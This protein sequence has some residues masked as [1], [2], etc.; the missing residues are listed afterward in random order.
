MDTTT[1]KILLTLLLFITGIWPVYIKSDD[2]YKSRTKQIIMTIFLIAIVAISIMVIFNDKN[3]SENN[4][5]KRKELIKFSS[6]LDNYV[7]KADIFLRLDNN[8]YFEDLNP[9][10]F[11]YEFIKYDTDLNIKEV[12]ISNDKSRKGNRALLSYQLY[13]PIR[14]DTAIDGA[15]H[16]FNVTIINQLHAEVYFPPEKYTLRKLNKSMLMVYLPKELIEKVRNI[17]LTINGWTFI[18]EKIMPSNWEKIDDIT[19]LGGWKNYGLKRK[20]F[21]RVSSEYTQTFDYH[22]WQIDMFNRE[23]IKNK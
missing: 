3:E 8:Y 19:K 22:P 14:G 23:I 17:K 18:D 11:G 4:E 16:I 2:F 21:Y 12:L 20:T 13:D 9:I 6:E 7:E 10:Y 15:L 5:I 1:L